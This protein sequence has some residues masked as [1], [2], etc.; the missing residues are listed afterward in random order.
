[1]RTAIL[2]LLVT[3]AACGPAAHAPRPVPSTTPRPAAAAPAAAAQ[4]L[5]VEAPSGGTP[6]EVRGAA[7]AR[8]LHDAGA[9]TPTLIGQ[10]FLATRESAVHDVHVP[11]GAC[12]TFAALATNGIRDLDAQLFHPSGELLAADAADDAHPTL[13][14][15]AREGAPV[16][17]ALRVVNYAGHGADRIAAFASPEAALPAIARA[18]GGTP[19][20]VRDRAADPTAARVADRLSTAALRGFTEIDE[21]R[22]IMLAPS[23][24]V[25]VPIAARLD[26]CLLV[27]V[28]PESGLRA[29]S[30]RLLD[31]DGSELARS[32]DPDSEATLQFCAVRH[33][34]LVLVV[35]ARRG[36]GTARVHTLSAPSARV[37]GGKHLW[38]GQTA[39]RR[40]AAGRADDTMTERDC[41]SLTRPALDRADAAGFRATSAPRC[42]PLARGEAVR[43]R[44]SL[45]AGHCAR[46]EV[47]A[48]RGV[49]RPAVTWSVEGEPLGDHVGRGLGAPATLHA[50]SAAAR[51][52]D[53]TLVAR[54][55][56]GLL[57]L[58]VTT[59]RADDADLEAEARRLDARARAL[60]AG[61]AAIADEEGVCAASSVRTLD[62][63]P[64]TCVRTT[65]VAERAAPV[66]ACALRG[67]APVACD[68]GPAPELAQCAPPNE[69][70]RLAVR[71]TPREGETA[72]GHW[73]SATHRPAL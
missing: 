10:G 45:E 60:V 24:S 17:F 59:R 49:A 65:F 71:C 9:A 29:V 31:G 5:P 53:A 19:G 28:V 51:E 39:T 58:V 68:A 11:G 30:A 64:G 40:D 14:V 67:E 2:A 72:R 43:A 54:S 16:R 38:F 55:G 21:P 56:S 52:L 61:G 47:V 8:L 37:S 34:E 42:L 70:R 20:R 63:A 18:I 7:L 50:C 33:R 73:I 6:L 15:C 25:W 41:A 35:T 62:I 66:S 32:T 4:S 27:F 44:F 48:G 12:M 46:V 26:E 57:G 1:M 23:Q 36:G 13:Q 22:E 69:R 3:I